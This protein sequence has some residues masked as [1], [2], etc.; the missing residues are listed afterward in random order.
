[1][2]GQ[3][4]G[5]NRVDHRPV[6]Q[7]A[8][9]RFGRVV[10]DGGVVPLPIGHGA[11]AAE[12]LVAPGLP[13]IKPEAPARVGHKLKRVGRRLV[14]RPRG[15]DDLVEALSPHPELDGKRAA[16]ARGTVGRHLE[17]GRRRCVGQGEGLIRA[18]GARRRID[19]HGPRETV[20][21]AHPS[22]YRV[23]GRDVGRE[24]RRKRGEVPLVCARVVARLHLHHQLV[25]ALNGRIE[26]QKHDARF[27]AGLEANRDG[28]RPVSEEV[29]IP[30]RPAF[31]KV[32]PNAV[33]RGTRVE[34]LE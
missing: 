8:E 33:D 18:A 12:G 4:L 28:R 10:D 32:Q 24:G 11:R 27:A 21:T 31:R 22:V 20:R 7:E 6:E 26:R 13:A 16:P 9:P 19:L 30:D 1:M 23:S 17:A 3:G 15:Q 2:C 29:S 14:A 25:R 5:L 34:G